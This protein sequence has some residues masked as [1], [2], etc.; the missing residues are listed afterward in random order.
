MWTRRVAAVLAVVPIA[1][2]LVAPAA[3]AAVDP[4]LRINSVTLDRST[5][6]VGSLNT[7][8]VTV[9]V[10]ADYPNDNQVFTAYFTR[11]GGQRVY[12]LY[13]LDLKKVSG[14][15]GHGIWRGVAN[16]P[17]VANGSLKV[18]A[19]YPTSYAGHL[20]NK[21]L[22]PTVVENGPIVVIK[23]VH[24]PQLIG[25]VSPAVVAKNKPYSIKWTIYD[26]ATRKPYGTKIKVQTSAD[27]TACFEGHGAPATTGTNGILV[28]QYPAGSDF[29]CLMVPGVPN[30][31]FTRSARPARPRVIS[32]TPSRT[33][34]R[35][36]KIVPV[37][38]T[39]ADAVNCAINL[40][41]LYGAS[42]WRIVG[43]I[44][45]RTSGRYTLNAQPSYQG[46]IPYRV[47]MPSCDK[48]THYA[49]AVSKTFY[50]T[51]V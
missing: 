50:I 45:V 26:T 25:V 14:P 42:A 6:T 4:E 30:A 34:A 24:V 47:Q 23:G 28:K 48:G 41:R 20:A 5:V 12:D 7:V 11:P 16:V 46:K 39:V 49:A 17:S 13:S 8:P 19:I 44:G 22:E 35:V 18:Y 29:Q 32:A 51:G 40:E 15:P 43:R 2:V 38:G 1:G 10:V 31:I 3:S 27:P 21:Q 33:S 36:G 37:N 9:S